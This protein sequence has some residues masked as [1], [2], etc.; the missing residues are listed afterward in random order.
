MHTQN[1]QQMIEA[2]VKFSIDSVLE[3]REW[4]EKL[5]LDGVTGFSRLTEQQLVQ[6]MRFR[7]LM[8]FED[9]NEP[10]ERDE[11]DEDDFDDEIERL[12]MWSGMIALGTVET[13]TE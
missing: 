8:G 10:L 12:V 3:R 7:G 4:L 13:S 2:L 5:F 11:D 6:E 1:K 9:E